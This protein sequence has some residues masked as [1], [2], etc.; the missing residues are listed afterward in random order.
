MKVDGQCHCGAIVYEAEVELGTVG[1]CHCLDCQQLTGSPF[2]TNIRAEAAGFRFLKGQPRHYIKTGD[3]GAQR[4]H[5]FC[6]ICGSPIYSAAIDNPQSY[7]LRLGAIRQRI[8][9]GRP[10]RQIW[11]K[12]RMPW[13]VSL[14]DVPEFTGE[15]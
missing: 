13:I 12:R 10:A 5:A 11:T 2:R 7:S 14:A 15:A 4:I 6:E 9:L 3:S 1:I 8:E